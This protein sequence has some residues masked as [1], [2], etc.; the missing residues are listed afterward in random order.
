MMGGRIAGGFWAESLKA[1]KVPGCRLGIYDGILYHGLRALRGLQHMDD[2]RQHVPKGA[3]REML[4]PLEA[5]K[6]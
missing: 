2:E 1:L 5:I 6:A 4:R 3:A